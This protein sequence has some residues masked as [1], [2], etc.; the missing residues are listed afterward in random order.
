MKTNQ[1]SNR[2]SR[3]VMIITGIAVVAVLVAGGLLLW[4]KH[5]IDSQHTS[6]V[7]KVGP[8]FVNY[9]PPTKQEKKDAADHKDALAKQMADENKA[10]NTDPGTKKDVKPVIT[11][12]STINSQVTV[13]AYIS[14]IFEDGGTCTLTATK[15][16]QQ[17]TFT[18]QGFADATTTDCQ[19]FRLDPSEFPGGGQWSFKVSY[20]SG[21]ASGSSDAKDYRVD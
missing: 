15:G 5:T 6:K 4:H 2:L 9:S 10:G 11:N 7:S 16:S 19:P 17:K 12:V 13:T 3:K 8:N 1:K 18:S 14:G 21:T 20:S